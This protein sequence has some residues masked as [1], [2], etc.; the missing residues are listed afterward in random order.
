MTI[1]CVGSKTNQPNKWTINEILQHIIYIERL[2]TAGTLRF[3]RNEYDYTIAFDENEMAK[4]SKANNRTIEQILEELIAV[5]TSTIALFKMI[6]KDDFQ[7]SSINWKNRITV[8]AMRFNSLG[9]QIYHLQF[10]QNNIPF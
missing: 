4:Q 7:K 10:I 6:D 1:K 2:L 8:E 9:H 3:A 5:R